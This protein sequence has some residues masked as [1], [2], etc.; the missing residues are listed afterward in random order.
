MVGGEGHLLIDHSFNQRRMTKGPNDF[1]GQYICQAAYVQFQLVS[2][3]TNYQRSTLLN[4][5]YLC[6]TLG[7]NNLHWEMTFIFHSFIFTY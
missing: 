7:L 3:S 2:A 1:S 5:S 4:L 6:G